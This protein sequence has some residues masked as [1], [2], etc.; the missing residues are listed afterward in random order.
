MLGDVTQEAMHVL[1]P[2]VLC[3]MPL[4][5]SGHLRQ[6][7]TLSLLQQLENQGRKTQM[8][9]EFILYYITN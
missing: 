7:G 3:E 8:P 4:R 2:K 6:Q 1:L 9:L 5:S